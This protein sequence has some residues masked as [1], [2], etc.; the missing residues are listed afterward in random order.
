MSE[1]SLLS[2]H[3]NPT[4]WQR[5]VWSMLERL[6]T[7]SLCID[8]QQTGIRTFGRGRPTIHV[9]VQQQ[10]F[11]QRLVLGGSVGAGEAYMDG[12]WQCDDLVGVIRLFAQ[13]EQAQAGLDGRYQW[14]ISLFNGVSHAFN[15]NS[16]N[17]SKRNIA[18]HYDLSN[19]FFAL[20][21]DRRMMYSSAVFDHPDQSLDEASTAKLARLCGKLELTPTDHLLE[22][23][24]GWGG[25]AIYA[26]QQFG[27]RVT[28]TTISAEQY[29]F[30]K[31]RVVAAG[32]ADQIT[33]L[34]KDYRELTQQF[35]KIV[36]VEMVEAVGHHYVDEYFERCDQL[37]KPGGLF[38]MQAITIEDHRYA[39]AVKSVD[40]IKKYIFPGSFIPSVTRLVSAAG[41]HTRLVLANLEDF[42]QDYAVTLRHWR[43]R[44]LAQQ[45]RISQLGFDQ[46][47]VRMWEFYLAYCEGGFAER[48]ISDVQLVFVKSGYQGIP[49]RADGSLESK[50]VEVK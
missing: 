50:Q 42:A 37:L 1:S 10:R 30:A 31:S 34:Q 38:V 23:G 35:D 27:C 39:A 2:T 3:A 49:W 43:E 46:R 36:S 16:L 26:A 48:A 33:V 24:T 21:L 4:F 6:E 28:T 11:Y 12:D 14:L 29:Q 7:G 45:D 47:F 44:T 13:N 40:F 5:I 8:D 18:A 19:E 32:L 20:F 9:Q 25:L 41:E 17:G 22:I 15:R